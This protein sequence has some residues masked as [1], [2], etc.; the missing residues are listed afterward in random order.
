MKS[1]INCINASEII[2]NQ[3]KQTIFVQKMTFSTLVDK[4]VHHS[5]KNLV[6]YLRYPLKLCMYV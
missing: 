6:Y 3:R 2:G 1:L 5:T 4:I